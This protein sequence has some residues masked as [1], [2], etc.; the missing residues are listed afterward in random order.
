MRTGIFWTL[1]C[2]LATS[3]V[4]SAQPEPSS[5]PK[6]DLLPEVGKALDL[7]ADSQPSPELVRSF[8]PNAACGL[9]FWVNADYLLWWMKGGPANT[10]LVTTGAINDIPPG[11][12]GQPGT[13]VIYGDRPFGFGTLSG[14]RLG[15]GI[16]LSPCTTLEGNYFLIQRGVSRF[17]AASDG[18]GNPLIA[19]PFFNNDLLDI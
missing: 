5:L 4:A 16:E 7:S 18:A 11:A 1:A 12:L 8:S 14:V 13:Q 9:R 3:S 2:V 10:P 17:R 19:R 15:A 6:S